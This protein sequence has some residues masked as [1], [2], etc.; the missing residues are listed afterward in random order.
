MPQSQ[1]LTLSLQQYSQVLKKSKLSRDRERVQMVNRVGKKIAMAAED[2][3]EESGLGGQ[4]RNY[5]WEF[6]LL[7]DD[8]VINAWCMPGGKVAVYTGIL[9]IARN[10]AGLAVI[11]GHE[12][13][14]AIANHGNER[15][16]Q[17]LLVSMGGMALSVALSEKP[18]QT[19]N[20]FMAAFGVGTSVGVLLPYSRL[21][22]SEADR[23]GLIL[24]ARAGYD[25]REAISFWGRMNEKAGPRPPEFLST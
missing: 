20:L 25:P 17:A 3:L 14:H 1:L 5:D 24:T 10:E 8:K 6:N 18:A 19:R 21:H 16:S 2:F 12:V 11:I 22:E 15:L 13:G 7:E 9:P 23:I 4:I